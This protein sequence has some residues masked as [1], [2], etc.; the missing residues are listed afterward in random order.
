MLAGLLLPAAAIA[1]VRKETLSVPSLDHGKPVMVPVAIFIPD[2]APDKAAAMVILHGS[3]GVS[4]SREYR[5]AREFSRMGVV[6]VIPD[7]FAARG[8]KSTVTDQSAVPTTDMARDL[9]LVLAAVARHP[10]IDAARIGA[11]GF[12]KG[13]SAVLQDALAAQAQRFSPGGP[14]FALHVAFYPSCATQFFDPTT[15]GAPVRLLIGGQD[16]YAGSKPCRD[17]AGR[18]KAAGGDVETV[19]YPQAQHDWDTG[20]R[21]WSNPAGENY[22]RC[23]YAE[24]A[25]HSWI[26]QTSGIATVGSDGRLV[27][28]AVARALALCRTSGVSGAPDEAARAQSLAAL[29]AYMRAALKL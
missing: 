21:P 23:V 14:R 1:Q 16:T 9:M 28:G 25:D 29:Q 3:G 26:E 4:D 5:Y 6:S 19:V 22:S 12:S 17:Y 11:V 2:T 15:T 18:L 24:Q 7:S 13:A 27:P 10:R 20:T 8:V